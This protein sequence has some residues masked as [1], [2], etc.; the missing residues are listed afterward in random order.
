M[1]H[2]LVLVDIEGTTTPITFVKDTLVGISKALEMFPYVL[3]NIRDFLDRKW[4]SP[5]LHTYIEHLREQGRQ[6]QISGDIDAVQIPDLAASPPEVVKQAVIQNVDAQMEADR[7]IG[8]LKAFQGYMWEEGYASGDLKSSVYNDVPVAFKRWTSNGKKVYIY[9]SG[10]IAAQKLL[11]EFSDKG[12]LLPYI[13]GHYDTTIGGKTLPSSYEA[14]GKSLDAS[15]QDILFISDNILEI[16][17]A[18]KAGLATAVSV[19]PGNAPI[20]P[21]RLEGKMVIESFDSLP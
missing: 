19:R 8:A 20:D 17:A 18:E 6:D 10:S 9:S 7:K 13:S 16:E 4:E 2:P 11:F 14:I 12:N 21:D 3:N 1:S 15:P 5:E